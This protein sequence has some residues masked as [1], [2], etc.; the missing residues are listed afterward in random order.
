MHIIYAQSTKTSFLWWVCAE[1]PAGRQ[2]SAVGGL[3]GS[4]QDFRV[5]VGGMSRVSGVSELRGPSYG[6]PI[7]LRPRPGQRL[8]LWSSA[9]PQTG[10]VTLEGTNGSKMKERWLKEDYNMGKCWVKNRVSDD[11]SCRRQQGGLYSP[12]EPF[13]YRFPSTTST[14]RRLRHMRYNRVIVFVIKQ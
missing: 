2:T 10:Q 11:L 1:K 8:G 4:S 3:Q 9:R 13:E 7:H 6:H 5:K 14:S 12:D